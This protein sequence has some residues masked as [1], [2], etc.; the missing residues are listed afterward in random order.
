MS[1][2]PVVFSSLLDLVINPLRA[3]GTLGQANFLSIYLVLVLLVLIFKYKSFKNYQIYLVGFLGILIFLIFKTASLTSFFSMLLGMYFLRKDLLQLDKKII[4]TLVIVLIIAFSLFGQI[5]KD[6]FKDIFNQIATQ[7]N[8]IISDSLLIRLSLWEGVIKIITTSPQSIFLG[9]GSE[10]FSYLFELNRPNKLNNLSEKYLVFDK[11][12]NYF[13]EI[14]FSYG[15]FHLSIFIFLIIRYFKYE[16]N[17]SYL[18]A[19]III[20]IF[21]NWLDLFLKVLLFLILFSGENKVKLN[22]VKF[23][24]LGSIVSLAMIFFYF[25]ILVF[26]D[27]SF[28]WGVNQYIFSNPKESIIG[29]KTKS[30][31]ILLSSLKFLNEDERRKVTFFLIK[32]FPKNKA[33][34]FQL[35][36]LN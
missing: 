12:H 7:N 21:F 13:L 30:P 5:Y 20:F 11:P 2:V 29:L 25:S 15:I 8:T 1:S 10:N 4:S 31:V 9:F 6:K 17:Y 22:E 34:N 24:T 32:N 14:L 18:L 23:F 3:S 33:I 26:R 19:P 28:Y 35:L 16:K 27:S 36:Q